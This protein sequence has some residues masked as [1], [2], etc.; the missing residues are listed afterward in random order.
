[1]MNGLWRKGFFFSIFSCNSPKTT[2]NI[3]SEEGA[4]QMLGRNIQYL[5]PE[6]GKVL[7]CCC[8]NVLHIHRPLLPP[9]GAWVGSTDNQG[10][11]SHTQAAFGRLANRFW[12]GAERRE[13]G[14]DRRDWAAACLKTKL[15]ILVAEPAEQNGRSREWESLVSQCTFWF[16][17]RTFEAHVIITSFS[18]VS[19]SLVSRFP[20]RPTVGPDAF[21]TSSRSTWMQYYDARG[22][23]SS[24][25]NPQ[26]LLLLLLVG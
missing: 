24:P 16:V 26:P 6:M 9:L 15:G 12:V 25:S 18:L 10:D 22:C 2:N 4:G 19:C 7:G 8:R 5:T 11:V 23:N 3:F 13:V 1:M 17:H 21:A 20:R 14:S